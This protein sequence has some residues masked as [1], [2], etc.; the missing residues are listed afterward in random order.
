M[1]LLRRDCTSEDNW[2]IIEILEHTEQFSAPFESETGVAHARERRTA[3]TCAKSFYSYGKSDTHI[4]GQD[5]YRRPGMYQC[6]A[7]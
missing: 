3:S 7:H 5:P 6:H 2:Q 4:Q 1:H